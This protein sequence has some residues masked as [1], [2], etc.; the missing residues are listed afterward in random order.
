M[1]QTS[2]IFFLSSQTAYHPSGSSRQ[3]H[4]LLDLINEIYLTA[5]PKF[6]FC[7]LNPIR[8]LVFEKKKIKIKSEESA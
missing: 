3:A 2:M 8:L 6:L 1:A 5:A 4:L 7:I